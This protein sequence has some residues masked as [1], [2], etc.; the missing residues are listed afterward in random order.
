MTHWDGLVSANSAGRSQRIC[1]LG[2]TN[3]MQ[4]ID[5][6]ILRRMPKK[7]PVSLPTAKQ[8]RGIFK[9]VLKDTRLDHDNFDWDYLVKISAGLSGSDIKEA[10]RDAAMLPMREFIKSKHAS[11]NLRTPVK[12]D[13]IRG[14]R[15]DDFF[16]RPQ[17]AS[18]TR[19]IA[20]AAQ[21]ALRSMEKSTSGHVEDLDDG[22][23]DIE[24]EG[25][26]DRAWE[27]ADSEPK[28]S[29]DKKQKGR[30]S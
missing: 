27:S 30:A 6:A 22:L 29:K 1:I 7:F 21:A 28:K 10:C 5:E 25:A 17:D 13:D 19:A 18:S 2:A 12:A 24:D 16:R 20:A 8:R 3:R 14:V 11:G 4:D 15:T 9:L 23:D 26:D